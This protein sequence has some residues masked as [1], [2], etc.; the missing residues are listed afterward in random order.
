MKSISKAQGKLDTYPYKF[1]EI[2]NFEISRTDDQLK[3]EML[4][5]GEYKA[6]EFADRTEMRKTAKLIQALFGYDL[7]FL[8]GNTTPSIQ[9]AAG[10]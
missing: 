10:A 8:H 4:K 5:K 2:A 6:Y 3:I 1:E 7:S 9:R